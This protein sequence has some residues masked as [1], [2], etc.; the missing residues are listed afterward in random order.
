M[1]YTNGSGRRRVGRV[2]GVAGWPGKGDRSVQKIKLQIVSF[3]SVGSCPM[4]S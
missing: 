1:G 3:F 2:D 4:S